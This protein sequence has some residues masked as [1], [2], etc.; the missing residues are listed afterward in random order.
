M[1]SFAAAAA[2]WDSLI[3]LEIHWS[4]VARGVWSASVTASYAF[5]PIFL[6]PSLSLILFLLYKSFILYASLT[7]IQLA[8]SLPVS[9]TRTCGLFIATIYSTLLL[10]YY[11]GRSWRENYRP[12]RSRP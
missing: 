12:S 7:I 10:V 4:K 11:S 1:L 8:E 9:S 2:F 6:F 5:F 3:N